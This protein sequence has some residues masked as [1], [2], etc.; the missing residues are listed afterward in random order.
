MKFI[1]TKNKTF[2]RRILAIINKNSAYDFDILDKKFSVE[3]IYNLSSSDD[4]K[5]IISEIEEKSKENEED[6]IKYNPNHIYNLTLLPTKENGKIKNFD[7]ERKVI[8][9][10]EY[11]VLPSNELLSNYE[12]FSLE[13][14][15]EYK[16]FLW[17]RV[18]EVFNIK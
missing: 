15:K 17:K 10:K 18:V 7:F 1:T 3:H 16:N 9:Y 8:K 13:L 6:E 5:K 14:I 11:K 12:H 4:F 2:S